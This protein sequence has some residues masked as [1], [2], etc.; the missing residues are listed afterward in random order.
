MQFHEILGERQAEACSLETTGAHL[1]IAVENLL[2]I[3]CGNARA[4][5]A[6]T[7]YIFIARMREGDADA[8]T[9]G[10]ELEGIAHDVVEDAFHLGLVGHGLEVLAPRFVGELYLLLCS[11]SL[12][13]VGPCREKRTQVDGLKVE[14]NLAAFRL[15]EI[16]NLVHQPAQQI[17]VP[18]SQLQEL[19][20]LGILQV[21]VLAELL[22][23]C[24][25]ECQW[26]AEVMADVSEEVHLGI[27]GLLE[28]SGQ[29][30]QLV[31]LFLEGGT[32]T[33]ETLSGAA[34]DAV[35]EVE[36]QN[37]AK[38]EHQEG[39]QR[40][41]QGLFE[42]VELPIVIHSAFQ[43]A[44]VVRFLVD[45]ALH[46]VGEHRLLCRRDE[47]A[48]EQRLLFIG[49]AFEDADGRL[50]DD[51][52]TRRV[53]SRGIETAQFDTFDALAR[54]HDAIDAGKADVV[55]RFQF[56]G[57]GLGSCCNPVAMGYDNI[58]IR[59]TCKQGIHHGGCVVTRPMCID[60]GQQFCLG[61]SLE[62]LDD[63]SMSHLG[64]RG[65][66]DTREFKDIATPDG[67]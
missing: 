44:N 64:R 57:L 13:R 34:T 12:E 25:D 40:A 5:V 22:D 36:R 65:S 29:G 23:G 67:V 59:I 41:A 50:H 32:L 47:V 4:G 18:L 38:G 56:V 10:S 66:H 14:R 6:D 15:A 21:L 1:V 31:T 48:F 27:V 63:A 19:P 16:E 45:G 17:D 37:E 52:A 8:A 53:G 49:L 35:E 61:M 9:I 3:A 33:G 30:E 51:V 20:L 11:Q 60:R 7:H 2:D 58:D 42:A 26:C 46:A 28:F 55:A 24:S 39:S 43:R 54:P 62:F